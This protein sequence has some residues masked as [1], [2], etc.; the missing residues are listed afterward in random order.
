MLV[1]CAGCGT[2]NPSSAN[3]CAECGSPVGKSRPAPTLESSAAPALSAERRQLSV[4]FCDLVGSTALSSRLDPEDLRILIRAYQH[5]VATQMERFGGFVARYLGDGVLVYFGWPRATEADAEQALRAALATTEAVAAPPI[6]G[7]TLRVRIGVA[8]GLVVVGDRA[9]AGEAQEQTAIGE[10][11]NVAARLQALAEPGGTVID[12]ATNRLTGGLFDVRPMGRVALKGLPEPVE[13]FEL[14]DERPDQSRLAALREPELT[15]LIGRQEELDLLLRRWR[16]AREGQGRVVLISGEPGIGKSRLLRELEDRL[17]GEVFRRIR[18]FCSQHTTD[19]P[20]HP[21][22][23]QIEFD[24][25]FVRDD[26]PAEQA[27]KLRARLEAADATIED[28]ALITTLLHLPSDGLPSFNLSPQR[29]KERTFAALLRRV[30]RISAARPTLILFEDLHWAD[31]STRELLDDLIRR[32]AELRVLLVMTHRPEFIAPWTGHAGVTSII[33]SRLERSEATML[34]EQLAAQVALPRTLLH[35]IVAQSDGVPLFLEELTKAVME[36]APQ[37]IAAADQVPVP[38]TLQASLIARLDRIPAARQVAQ[39]GA[40]V[41]RSFSRVLLSTVADLPVATL[42]E[43][44]DQLVAARLLFRRG[45]G[46]EAIYMFKHALVQEVAYNSLLRACRA[47]LHGAIGAVME[48]DRE[49]V[50]SRPA[51]LGHHFSR[52]GDAE[53]ASLFFLRA[54]EQSAS[55]SAM[56]EAEAHLTRG[57]AHAA[58][59]VSLPDRTRR[60][61]ELTLTLGNVRMAVHGV[62]SPLHKAAFVEAADLCRTLDSSDAAS[63]RLLARALFGQWSYELQAGNMSKGLEIGRELHTAAYSSPDPEL[64]AAASGYAIGYTFLARLDEALAA[65]APAIADAGIRTHSAPAIDFGFDPICHLYAQYARS[66]ALRGFPEQ[67]RRHLRFA[68]D[69]A[70]ELQHL[71]TTAL[72]LMIACTTNWTMRDHAALIECSEALVRIASEQSYGFWLARGKSYAGWV[73][74]AEGEHEE[75]FAMLDEALSEF[76]AMRIWLSGPH[77]RA[78]QADVYAWMGRSDLADTAI[79]DA[80]AICV[81]TG[82]VW[83][84]ADLHRRRGELRRAEPAAAE[85]CFQHAIAIASAQGTKLFE[86]RASVSLARLQRD[87]GRRTEGHEKLAPIYGWFTEGFDIPDLVEA[88][89]LPSFIKPV[90]KRLRREVA[91]AAFGRSAASMG[92]ASRHAWSG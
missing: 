25:D 87:Q 4:L 67:A 71:P 57:L 54:G 76:A 88:S 18:L 45:E 84:K 80:L 40:V 51:L 35:R 79:D 2:L 8:T 39:I 62:G 90:R 28:V 81:L 92:A 5:R 75:G 53:K 86:L 13:A 43:G 63:L 73:K 42:D 74:A 52:A 7:E 20:L 14:R 49:T 26:L 32:S 22:I 6:Q 33:L 19:T 85:E 55:A 56:A 37:A 12:V 17:S 72:T 46:A 34:A 65:F 60:K 30:E 66:L 41:G 31:P 77:T 70:Q 16:Q 82:E 91:R 23:R 69:R 9:D 15:P 83:P 61:A 24:A 1:A 78:M 48:S 29:R 50:T 27:K 64:R 21:V 47:A 59:I 58:Q 44:L 3:F 11:P 10:T 68:L 38:A 36:A 89:R